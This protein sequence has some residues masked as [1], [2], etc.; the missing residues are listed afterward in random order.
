MVNIHVAYTEPINPPNSPPV[1]IKEQVWN[2][3]QRKIRHA[4]EFV[5]VIERTE[6]LEENGNE[7]VRV[8]HFAGR[9]GGKGHEIREVCRSYWPTK[10]CWNVSLFQ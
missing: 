10:V 2:G 3:L 4:E 9:D 8:A 7:V 6:V 1:L 5:P